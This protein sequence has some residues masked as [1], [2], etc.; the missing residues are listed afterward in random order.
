ML[1]VTTL[2][3]GLGATAEAQ[4]PDALAR[5]HILNAGINLGWVNGILETE[6]G[7]TPA[8]QPEIATDLANAAAAISALVPLISSPPYDT[9]P[10][11]AVN[12]RI[13][14]FANGLGAMS[15]AQALRE[16]AQIRASMRTALAVYL[17]AR[18]RRVVAQSNCDA[19]LF[20]VGYHF[21][22]GNTAIQRGN[23]SLERRARG[24]LSE[25]IAGGERAAR[26]LACYF[27]GGALRSLPVM[28]APSPSTYR[29]ARPRLQAMARARAGSLASPGGPSAAPPARPATGGV[30]ARPVP[31]PAP[32]PSPP[33][34]GAAGR[35]DLSCA[36]SSRWGAI[37]WG[38]GWYG[39]R[40]KTLRGQLRREGGRWVYRGTWG[41]TDSS[42]TGTVV[43]T[44]DSPTHFDGYYT[45]AG[46]STRHGWSGSGDCR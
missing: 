26:R 4:A 37:H 42:R 18:T 29:R 33:P 25:A 43:F 14:R 5:L 46:S 40:N 7:L 21:G 24:Q 10:F 39:A 3:G 38:E 11:V 44:F 1:L 12:E 8:N 41:R 35:P 22:T 16:I 27:P 13:L 45:Y 30:H 6:G 19:A 17:D 23:T 15:R 2:I 31:A 36:W 28:S 34:A 20:D 9:R 32:A